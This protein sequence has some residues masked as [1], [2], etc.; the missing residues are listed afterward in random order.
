[1]TNHRD[2]EETA[3]ALGISGVLPA[4][5]KDLIS[6]AAGEIG[7]G[8][9][10][11]AKAV[12]VALAPIE[13]IVWSYDRIREWLPP[14]ITAVLARRNAI[15][16]VPPPLSLAGQVTLNMVFASEEDSLRD[17]YARLLASAMDA[18]TRSS[19]HPSFSSVIQQLSGDEAVLLRK[20][21]DLPG[22]HP[23]WCSGS[24]APGVERRDVWQQMRDFCASAGVPNPELAELYVENL[25]R[26]RLLR[27]E[28]GMEAEFLPEHRYG[29][30][31]A[32]I[33]N[34]EYDFIEVT[35]YGRAFI[36]T[37][38]REESGPSQDPKQ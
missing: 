30:Y 27:H 24:A 33:V 26:L 9:A 4:M 29:H 35:A 31:E 36:D 12:N 25:I 32:D 7:S 18:R 15:E 37:C 11:L 8:L 10:T 28:S 21:A 16:V 3:K 14:R 38:V 2:I 17:M 6:P 5:Y 34:K 20:I 1:M 22:S 19:A 13:A 23:S